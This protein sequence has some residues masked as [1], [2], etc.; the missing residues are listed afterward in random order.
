MTGPDSQVTPRCAVLVLA[1]EMSADGRPTIESQRRLE[2]AAAEFRARP[3]A[4]LVTSGWGYREDTDT[5]LADAMAEAAIRDYGIPADRVLRLHDSRDTVGDAVFFASAVQPQSLVVVTSEYH[6]IRTEEIFRFVLGPDAELQVVGSGMA[7]DDARRTA[8]A[9]S[10]TA[11]RRTFE[12][13]KPGDLVSISTR[14]FSR[15]P[16]Y[17]GSTDVKALRQHD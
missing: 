16:F 3:D 12:G 15:H 9:N 6:R 13:I 17:N 4:L 5:T 10:L 8:E 11:F 2:Q 14:M 1:N 7:G